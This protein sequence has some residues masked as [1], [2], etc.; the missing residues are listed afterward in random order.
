MLLLDTLLLRPYVFVF[1]AVYLAG[2]SLHLGLKRALLFGIAGYAIA[3]LSEFSSIHNGFPYG[4]YYYL[5]G[6]MGKEIWVLGVPL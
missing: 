4:H 6:T 2:C 5:N 3:W 1:L